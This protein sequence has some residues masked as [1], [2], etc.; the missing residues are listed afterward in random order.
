MERRDR[1]GFELILQL[2]F[3]QSLAW[4]LPVLCYDSTLMIFR[5][6]INIY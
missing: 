6:F 2:L 4:V 1:I 5:Q 3:K